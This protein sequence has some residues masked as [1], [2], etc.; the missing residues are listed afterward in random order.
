MQVDTVIM[1]PNGSIREFTEQ[2]WK[3]TYFSVLYI[4]SA[5]DTW[6]QTNTR[7]VKTA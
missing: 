4:T 3:R 1:G 7:F 6:S 2:N 5:C